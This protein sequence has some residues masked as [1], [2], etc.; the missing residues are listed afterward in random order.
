MV[1]KLSVF[2][3]AKCDKD[4]LSA[5]IASLDLE[6]QSITSNSTELQTY[7]DKLRQMVDCN[8]NSDVINSLFDV[9]QQ[10]CSRMVVVK[11]VLQDLQIKRGLLKAEETRCIKR[12]KCSYC[13]PSSLEVEVEVVTSI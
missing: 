1:Q 12:S 11:N 5:G 10:V 6:I 8:G 7:R 9:Y 13:S 3:D 4:V 2:L